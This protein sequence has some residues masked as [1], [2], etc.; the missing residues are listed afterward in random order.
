MAATPI[1]DVIR[2]LRTSGGTAGEHYSFADQPDIVLSFG[3]DVDITEAGFIKAAFLL[4]ADLI[5]KPL[6]FGNSDVNITVSFGTIDD[7]QAGITRDNPVTFPFDHH[8]NIVVSRDTFPD[9]RDLALGSFEFLTILHELGHALGLTHPGPYNDVGEL[10]YGRDNV[11]PEDTNQYSIMSYFSEQSPGV[12]DDSFAHGGSESTPMLHDIAAI[13]AI[14]G[15][16]MSTRTG[17]NIYGFNSNNARTFSNGFSFDPYDFAKVDNPVFTIWD[18]GGI[19]TIDA[20][21][22]GAF[23]NAIGRMETLAQRID[24]REGHYSSIGY[25]HFDN[26]AVRAFPL[27]NNIAI[28]YGVTIENA[29]GGDGDD[30]I[31]G[32]DA[33]NVLT[34]NR[35]DDLMFGAGGNDR[36]IGGEGDDRLFGQGDDDT[37]IGGNGNDTLLG[38]SGRDL[39]EGGAGEDF[40]RGDDGFDTAT[41]ANATS[42]IVLSQDRTTDE[43]QVRG[44]T[45]VAIEAWLLTAYDDIF[46]AFETDDQV[47]GNAG[48][49]R[50]FGYG[51]KDLLIGGAGDDRLEGGGDDDNLQGGSGIDTLIGGAGNDQLDGGLGADLMSG[52]ADDD[53]Y[54]VNDAGDTVTESVL[55]VLSGTDLVFSFIDYTLGAGV[56]NLTLAGAA[57]LNG[58]GNAL[59]NVIAGNGG[60]NSLDGAGGADTMIGRGGNDIYVVDNAADIVDESSGGSADIDTVR[61]AISFSLLA[62]A[63]VRGAV[64]NLVLTGTAAINGTGNNLANTITGNGA[65]NILIGNGGDDRLDG[66]G[67]IDTM[68]GGTGNDTYVVDNASDRV[69]ETGG[70]SADIDTVLASVSFNL[71]NLAQTQGVVENVTLTGTAAINATGNVFDNVLIGNSARN[72]LTASGGNDDLTGGGGNDSLLGGSGN[73]T[74]RFSGNFGIDTIDD[75]SGTADRIVMTGSTT[76][77]ATSRAGNDLVA[78]FS[79]GTITVAN[80][81]TTGTVESLTFNGQTVVLARTLVGGD[82]PGIITGTQ[83]SETLDGRGGDD[84]LYA[85]RG[86]DILLGGLGNDLLD[87]GRGNDVLDGG[88]GNDILTGGAG[89]DIFVFRP[90]ALDGGSGHDV[91]TDFGAGDVIDLTAF[92]LRDSAPGLAAATMLGS[93]LYLDAAL[94]HVEWGAG[95][96]GRGLWS[97]DMLDYDQGDLVITLGDSSIRIEDIRH[98]DRGDFIV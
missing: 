35:G 10:V 82:L 88:A 11:Y 76:L 1:E 45:F 51:G 44:D 71:F 65:A 5:D 93:A 46:N 60:A 23:E 20:S 49:D 96:F 80:H 70:G 89:R 40:M 59:A 43:G 14:Y 24:L 55:F 84:F 2:Y 18:A 78:E 41:F 77:Q 32:N 30:R 67:G 72:V 90:S 62:S 15:A 63:T 92:H 27:I 12:P 28:A 97:C 91:I 8:V 42:R 25:T 66:G 34:G 95:P 73:D 6:L 22:Y 47:D 3:S 74:Y 81:F 87:G 68:F 98:L 75:E 17:D 26:S 56:E 64:E 83:D 69:D 94:M 54:F 37:L 86:H 21:G 36:L 57:P 52:G 7:G 61:A 50:I 38:G 79:T 39:L 9:T 33:D 53:V 48:N 13:Q 31:D 4:W 19:D 58:T 16:N 85:G 29:I